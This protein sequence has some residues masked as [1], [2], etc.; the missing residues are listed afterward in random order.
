LHCI[1]IYVSNNA[2][3][4]ARDPDINDCCTWL[5]VSRSYQ[6]SLSDC[7]NNDVGIATHINEIGGSTMGNRHCRINALAS[8]QQRKWQSN[9][10]R[11]TKNYGPLAACG[12]AVSL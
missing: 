11:T 12:D 3:F 4:G 10:C 1:K 2:G 9:Q 5:D 8:Q 7:P 6:M